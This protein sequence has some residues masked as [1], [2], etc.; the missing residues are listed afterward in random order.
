EA[1]TGATPILCGIDCRA[2]MGIAPD[3]KLLAVANGDNTIAVWET[4]TLRAAELSLPGKPAAVLQCLGKVEAFVFSP[5][6]KRLATAEGE[7]SRIYEVAS[8][9]LVLTLKPPGERIFAIAYSPDGK[10]LATMGNHR[11]GPHY[12]REEKQQR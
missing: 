2:G 8:K 3:G 1:A 9:Q 4:A 12:A 7:C 10:L 11:L 6:G 5:D